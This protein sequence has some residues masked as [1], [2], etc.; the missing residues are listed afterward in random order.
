MNR[1]IPFH[2]LA[3]MLAANCNISAEEAE[4]FIRNFFD[5]AAQTLGEGEPVRIKGIGSFE[6]SGDSDCPVIFIPDDSIADTI[7][8]PFA[9]FEPE[10]LSDTIT[11]ETLAEI[12]DEGRTPAETDETETVAEETGCI[13]EAAPECTADAECECTP[14]AES[15]CTT[16]AEPED[17]ATVSHS[18]SV[19][20]VASVHSVPQAESIPSVPPA[21]S[22]H[23][24][25][26]AASATPTAEPEKAPTVPDTITPGAVEPAVTKPASPSFPEDEPEE[27][28]EEPVRHKSGGGFGLGF[29]IGLLAGL[30][31]GACAVYFAIDYIMP[32]S[33]AAIE[34]P[35]TEEIAT[36]EEVNAVLSEAEAVLSGDTVIAAAPIVPAEQAQ[37]IAALNKQTAESSSEA[38]PQKDDATGNEKPAVQPQNKTVKDKVRPGYLLHDMAKK[39][40][41]NKCFWV[42]IYEENRSKISNPNRVSPGL[43]LTIPA[44]EKYGINASSQASINTANAKASKI[45]A[46]YPR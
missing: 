21:A 7:N 27:Y 41:G 3:A 17:T 13:T 15:E 1:K 12:S 24:D 30:A 6:T 11:E 36:E 25:L 16:E 18:P 5:L 2:E 39:H 22:V 23:S 19:P 35:A 32:T 33:P 43:E 20:P 14:E 29:L 40:Y 26:P 10:D 31:I 9:L 37:M 46:K 38:A 34:E 44:A 4:D 45:L 42:Y 28:I 8:A